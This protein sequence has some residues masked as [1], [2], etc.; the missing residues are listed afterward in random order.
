MSDLFDDPDFA[1]AAK[2]GWLEGEL[3]RMG[4]RHADE[5]SQITT[6]L[7]ER[8]EKAPREVRVSEIQVGDDWFLEGSWVQVE[9][10]HV[11][12][13]DDRVGIDY[14]LDGDTVD[15]TSVYRGFEIAI[16][17]R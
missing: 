11:S 7:L 16:V 9:E 4:W 3:R 6:R 13:P 1:D 15:S 5:L 8:L 2:L 17:K 10:V 12:H 14:I